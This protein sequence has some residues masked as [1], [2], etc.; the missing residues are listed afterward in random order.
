MPSIP[1]SILIKGDFYAEDFLQFLTSTIMASLFLIYY[2][3]LR[4]TL[5]K[6]QL[7]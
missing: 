7:I 4:F 6:F 1:K 5:R 3:G 2:N